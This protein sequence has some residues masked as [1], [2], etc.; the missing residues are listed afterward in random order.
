MHSQQNI[1]LDRVYLG[2]ASFPWFSPEH[3]IYMNSNFTLQYFFTYLIY[4]GLS[5]MVL[6]SR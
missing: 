6:M 4:I 2:L 5:V 3:Q 1:K